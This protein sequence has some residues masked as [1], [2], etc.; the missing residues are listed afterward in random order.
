MGERTRR[1][2]QARLKD[3]EAH[4]LQEREIHAE[5]KPFDVQELHE[6]ASDP[7]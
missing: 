4:K 6:R 5:S 3:P 7:C 2:R 1:H